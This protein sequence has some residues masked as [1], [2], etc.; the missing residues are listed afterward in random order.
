MRASGALREIAVHL[1]SSYADCHLVV[2][3]KRVEVRRGMVAVV[4][5]DHY[6]EEAT[7]FWLANARR[8]GGY[9]IRSLG[10]HI[11]FVRRVFL[12]YIQPPMQY[13]VERQTHLL[14]EFFQSKFRAIFLLTE[15][16]LPTRFRQR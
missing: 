8:D 1:P 5:G 2:A 11:G 7:D 16:S 3:I 4:H 12:E 10:S 14:Q 15:N 6:P 9:L 13:Q